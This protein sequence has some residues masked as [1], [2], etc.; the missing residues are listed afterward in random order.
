[1]RKASYEV[2][3]ATAATSRRPGPARESHRRPRE[4]G[5]A[6]SGRAR[7]G[8]VRGAG[9]ASRVHGAVVVRAGERPGIADAGGSVLRTPGAW[10]A[11]IGSASRAAPGWP[12]ACASRRPPWPRE[13]DPGLVVIAPKDARRAAAVP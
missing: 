7:E 8:G 13:D 3:R 6:G 10:D 12:F 11:E 2:R 5:R 9:D 4:L 1:M